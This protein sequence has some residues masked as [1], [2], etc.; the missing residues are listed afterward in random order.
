MF[1]KK[2]NYNYKIQSTYLIG[3]KSEFMFISFCMLIISC[4]FYATGSFGLLNIFGIRREVQ[5]LL[6]LSLLLLSPVI[7]KNLPKLLRK[8]IFLIILVNFLIECM[9]MQN[10]INIFDRLATV[11]VGGILLSLSKKYSEKA[12]KF[13]IAG[14]AIFSIMAIVQAIIIFFKPEFIGLLKGGYESYESYGSLTGANKII[15]SHPIELLGFITAEKFNFLG[16]YITRFRSFAAEPS[17]LV[18]SFLIP[19]ILALSY[20]DG[21]KLLSIPILFFSLF[22]VQ[23]G[24]IWISIALG[25]IACGLFYLFKGKISLLS[26]LPF[27]T[28]LMFF[29][30]I[31]Q[32]DIPNFVGTILQFLNPL[33]RNYSVLNKYHSATVRIQSIANYLVIAKQYPLGVPTRIILPSALPSGLLLSIYFSSGIIGLP[34]II[35][36]FYY[37]FKLT[38]N[39]FELYKGVIGLAAAL[40][41]GIFIQVLCFSDYGWNVLPGFTILILTICRLE[42]LISKKYNKII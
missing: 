14:A 32:I 11:L 9:L 34:L 37:I 15:I 36:T 24:T 26:I 16:Y 28:V 4:L 25:I 8:P 3:N 18:Y 6:L 31:S 21:T 38:I 2:K 22:L 27:F 29:I 39:C 40:L 10:V 5:I 30:F 41:Y 17:V 35:I 23:S 33:S 13:I 7:L 19:G 20:K 12:L 42:I 1:L